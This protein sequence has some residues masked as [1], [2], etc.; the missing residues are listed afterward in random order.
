MKTHALLALA[1]ALSG[2]VQA[3]EEVKKPQA[4]TPPEAKAEA[5]ARSEERPKERRG[6]EMK[7][8]PF[9]GV[10]TRQPSPEVRTMTGVA[11]GFGL[12]VEEVMPN[13]PAAKAGIQRYDLVT[14]FNDQRLANMEQLSALVRAT[15]KDGDVSLTVKR[16]GAEQK[17]SVKIGERMMPVHEEGRHGFHM[18]DRDQMNQWMQGMKR[19]MPSQEQMRGVMDEMREKM[20]RAGDKVQEMWKKHGSEHRGEGEQRRPEGEQRRPEGEQRRPE[21]EQRRPEPKDAPAPAKPP[22]KDEV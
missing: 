22:G 1:L 2:A 16:A 14:M 20:E 10:V 8:A 11:E 21:G 6:P 15:G 3:Q 5:P 9:L 12:V 19:S 18:P 4:D 7:P 13:S 17:I